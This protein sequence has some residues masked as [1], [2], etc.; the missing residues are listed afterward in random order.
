MMID[1]RHRKISIERQ[2]EL[3]GLS[4]SSYYYQ[5]KGEDEYN[6]LLM[7]LIDEQYTRRPILGVR[8]MTDYL[9]RLG[10]VVNHK[11]VA[12]LM[13]L[14]AIYPRPK[15]SISSKEHRKYPYLLRGLSIDRPNQVWCTDVTYIRLHAGFVYLTA[16]MDW[17]SRYVLSWR[18]SNTL[19]TGFCLEALDEALGVNT[20]DIF[21]SDQGVQFTSSAFTSLLESNDVRISMDGVGRCFDNIMVERL[22]RSVKY[23]EVYL[24][25]YQSLPEAR[26][27]IS[28]YFTY[29]NLE[30]P[31][32]SHDYR[33]PYEV[34]NNLEWGASSLH[35]APLSTT[36]TLSN[37]LS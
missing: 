10:H 5:A 23:E 9:R 17:Y 20:P 2:C 3:V 7:R 21:N 1:S 24:K 25:D 4:R 26:S 12:R 16:I 22:W 11:R 34:Y 18:L 37:I 35:S 6:L 29:Y 14:S 8:R 28:D 36:Q 27:S 31:H 19:D 33:T 13:G 15:T 30:R 32:Q